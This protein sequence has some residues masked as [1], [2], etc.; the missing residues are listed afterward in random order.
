LVQ[1]RKENRTIITRD[2]ELF[3]ACRE[4]MCR[5]F[6]PASK[7]PISLWRCLRGGFLQLDPKRC[8]LC[9]SLLLEIESNRRER[10]VSRLQKPIGRRTLGKNGKMLESIRSARA[11]CQAIFLNGRE[12]PKSLARIVTTF[13]LRFRRQL[14]RSGLCPRL[15]AS[16][17]HVISHHGLDRCHRPEVSGIQAEL[18][19][20][21]IL[22]AGQCK[23]ICKRQALRD[24]VSV[25]PEG[26]TVRPHSGRRPSMAV[27]SS[28]ETTRPSTTRTN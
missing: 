15:S 27:G 17:F 1:A 21:L 3:Q 7:F 11:R 14:R 6:H 16:H 12:R 20:V 25:D 13:R 18:R 10:G 8:T 9:N 26:T 2:K 19:L 4:R 22:I 23:G 24:R 28:G 5:A